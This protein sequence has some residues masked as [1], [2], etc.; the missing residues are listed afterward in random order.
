MWCDISGNAVTVRINNSNFTKSKP[1]SRIDIRV[2]T[3]HISTTANNM[4]DFLF[5]KVQFNNNMIAFPSASAKVDATGSVSI[6]ANNG[7]VKI[8][9][10]MVNFISN[11]HLGINGGALAIL[12][13]YENGNIHSILI[14]DCKFVGNKSPGHGAA[15]YID[16]RNDNDNIVIANTIFEH[17]VGGNSIFIYKAS[18]IHYTDL[19]HL[20]IINQ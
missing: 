12:F 20:I 19:I 17:N 4:T 13:P 8:N 6:V 14:T 18:C 16:T 2:P 1:V 15:L 3:L 9:M 11:Q 5:E 7:D 10:Y